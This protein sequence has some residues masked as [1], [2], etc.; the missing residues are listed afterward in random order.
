MR[1]HPNAADSRRRPLHTIIPAMAQ[2][3][4]SLLSFGVMGG[5]YQAAGHAQF[6]MNLLDL[7]CNLQTALDLPRTFCRDGLLIAEPTLSDKILADL[8]KRGHK[9]AVADS[10]LGG[11]QAILHNRREG[12]ITAASDFRKDGLALGF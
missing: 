4:D 5:D 3:G 12:V 10:P 2:S 6:L 8:A 7:N 11:G 1:G 9:I